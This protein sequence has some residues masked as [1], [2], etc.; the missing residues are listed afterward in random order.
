VRRA[1]AGEQIRNYRGFVTGVMLNKWKMELRSRRRH[2]TVPLDGGRELPENRGL[3][4]EASSP[5]PDDQI[6]FQERVRLALELIESLSDARRR[7]VLKLRLACGLS[8]AEVQRAM[9]VTE[10]TYR[11]LLTEAMH[12]I[13]LKLELVE[14]GRWCADRREVIVAYTEGRAN[15]D[16]A[17]QARRHLHS[18]PACRQT[19]GQRRREPHRERRPVA[20]RASP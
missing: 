4:R 5:P 20:M 12:D 15:E 14:Q 19:Y 13:D 2:P 8:A 9:G 1:Q 3:Q 6:G 16:E 11:R 7:Q 18:C 17:A 10:R